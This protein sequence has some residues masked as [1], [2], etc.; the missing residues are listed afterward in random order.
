[1]MKMT[2]LP[3]N[4]ME[5]LEELRREQNPSLYRERPALQL[6]VPEPPPGWEPPQEPEED[7][8]VIIIK[9]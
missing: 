6:P 8:R 1:M 3:A 5:H 2:R 9:L 7:S 4:W